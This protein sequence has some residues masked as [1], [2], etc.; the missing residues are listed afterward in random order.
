MA[1]DINISE[2]EGVVILCLRGKLLF[3]EER[4]HFTGTIKDLLAKNKAR[5]I[6]NMEKINSVDDSLGTVVAAWVSAKKQGGALKIA[7]PSKGVRHLLRLS[8][9]DSVFEVY[10]TEKD[11]LASFNTTSAPR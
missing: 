5:I 3:G 9:L 4:N 1:L 7:V 6:L 2:T 10:A 8:K 11:A